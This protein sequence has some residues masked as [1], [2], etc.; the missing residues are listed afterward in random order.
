MRK[1][2]HRVVG[3]HNISTLYR[4]THQSA[5]ITQIYHSINRK[6]PSFSRPTAQFFEET[7]DFYDY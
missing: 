1:W 3:L 4:L 2:S 5:E 7:R 6:K